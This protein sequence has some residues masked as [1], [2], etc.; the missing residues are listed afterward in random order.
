M[1]KRLLILTNA[2]F[3]DADSNGRTLAKL[4]QFYDK[5]CLAQFFVYGNP[6]FSVCE[7]YYQVSDRAALMSMLMR[8]ETGGVVHVAVSDQQ[9]AKEQSIHGD[10]KVKKT[11]LNLLLRETVWK[12]GRWNGKRF[13]AWVEEFQP[14]AIFVSV[15]ANP[16]L[17][18]LAKQLAR[19][20]RLP[21]YVYSTE[22]YYFMDYNYLTKR[23]SLFYSLFHAWIKYS[24]RD[25]QK[26]VKQGIFNTPL[27]QERYAAEFPF[28]CT[29]AY[30]PSDIDFQENTTLR[31]QRVVSYLGNL[32][33]NRHLALIQLAKILQEIIPDTKLDVYGMIPNENVK[34]A[35]NR[36]QAIRYH[37]V[38]PYEAVVSTIHKSDLVV[39]AEWNDPGMNKTIQ[40]GFTTKIADSV[41]SG[42]PF[43]AF[44][45]KG[46]AGI[47]FLIRNQ[48]AFVAESEEELREQLRLALFDEDARRKVIENAKITREKYFQNTDDMVR[49]INGE[50]R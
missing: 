24:Y 33:L 17:C 34:Q 8:K 27:L 41:C 12:L 31:E 22:S 6:D 37:G 47:D 13:K 18:R 43:L 46:L 40:Y 20:Y 19:N 39:H 49:I 25:L 26:Y 38:I 23:P 29:C 42:T 21:V 7:R 1:Q 36:C 30:S 35:F 10:R 14:E 9:Y 32:G 48:C 28:P 11:P 3:F 50:M 5:S 45:H 16:H 2:C 15:A 44:A 4:F